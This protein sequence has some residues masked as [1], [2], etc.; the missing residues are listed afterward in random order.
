MRHDWIDVSAEN[1]ILGPPKRRCA[2]CRATQERITDHA[3]M[4]EERLN[5]LVDKYWR[6]F[7][8]EAAIVL[9]ALNVMG[10]RP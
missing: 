5:Y 10:A 2:N 9:G 4:R 7:R 1:G 3:W 8:R 6:N